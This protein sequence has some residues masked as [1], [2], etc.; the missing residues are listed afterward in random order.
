MFLRTILAPCAGR[1]RHTVEEPAR[2]RHI[3]GGP[4]STNKFGVRGGARRQAGNYGQGRR[5]IR[6]SWPKE[7]IWCGTITLTRP[8]RA[9]RRERWVGGKA[10]CR[11]EGLRLH[12]VPNDVMLDLLEQLADEPA[13]ADLRYVLA[14]LLVRRRVCRLEETQH[15]EQGLETLVLFCA[16]RDRDYRVS[17]AT[18]DERRAKEI[19]EELV[20]LLFAG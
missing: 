2:G 3:C 4:W 6:C 11:R 18:P 9:R 16:R 10:I 14:L 5:C 7:R 1:Y 17:V 15:D 19:Q 13:R 20:R 12:W 8:G